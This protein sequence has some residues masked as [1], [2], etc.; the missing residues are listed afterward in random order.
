MDRAQAIHSFWNSF[1]LKAYDENTVPDNAKL[2]Y[3]TYEVA[4]SSF[5][6]GDTPLAEDEYVDYGEQKIY[7]YIDNVLTPIDPP[8]ALPALPTINGTT[9]YDT[10]LSPKPE[11][12]EAEADARW[13]PHVPKEYDNGA[14]K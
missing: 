1:G 4:V 5:D 12:M 8:V 7:K 10:D 14:W 3:I 6:D 13:L 2:P 11:K 9:V